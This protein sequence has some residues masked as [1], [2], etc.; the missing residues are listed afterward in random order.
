ML[1]AC[2]TASTRRVH[3]S[4]IEVSTSIWPEKPICARCSAGVGSPTLGV[5]TT[6]IGGSRKVISSSPASFSDL[7]RMVTPFRRTSIL[8]LAEGSSKSE[9]DERKAV[10]S[11]CSGMCHFSASLVCTERMSLGKRARK[12]A[13]AP[14]WS[15]VF[16]ASSVRMKVSYSAK[17]TGR[18]CSS[19]CCMVITISWGRLSVS[20]EVS[21]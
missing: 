11:C 5:L 3:F 9:H 17:K 8:W 4:R 13:E 14:N 15:A 18:Y 21:M 19:M 12:L 6:S 10:M 7:R 16:C 1:P 2:C 20:D